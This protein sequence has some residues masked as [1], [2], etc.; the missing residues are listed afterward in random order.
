MR[1]VASLALAAGLWISAAPKTVQAA[2]SPLEQLARTTHWLLTFIND[3]YATSVTE[4]LTATPF[5]AAEA[6]RDVIR[7]PADGD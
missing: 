2:P 3:P 5:Q 4:I 6:F 1:Y 7:F